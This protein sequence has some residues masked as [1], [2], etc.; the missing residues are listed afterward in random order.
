MQAAQPRLKFAV[1][2]ASE[3]LAVLM[4]THLQAHPMEGVTI[5]TG[6]VHTLM[7]RV[8]CG[9]VASGTATLEAA[10]HGLPYCLVY[11]VAW[12]TW[13]FGKAVIRVPY[14][15]MVNLLAK[16]EVVRELIQTRC[17]PP[18]IAGEL[19]RLHRDAAIRVQLQQELAEV[20]AGLAGDGAYQRA[21]R[22]M[23]EA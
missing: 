12:G 22:A 19:N 11:K 6:T 21:A 20:V 15:G 7:Q 17:T 3:K 16:R 4:R 14:L 2:A 10:I 9:A 5:Q 13:L 18:Q 1:S 23:L 8:C